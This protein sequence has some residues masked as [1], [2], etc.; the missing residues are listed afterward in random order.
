MR[1][2]SDESG[3]S[4][5]TRRDEVDGPVEHRCGVVEPLPEVLAAVD[6]VELDVR[7]DGAQR[8]RRAPRS[9]RTARARRRCRA[10]CGTAARRRAP[11]APGSP[12]AR[13]PAARPR[14][15]RSSAPRGSRSGGSPM[16]CSAIANRSAGPNQSTTPRT[17]SRRSPVSAASVAP[18]E[19]PHSTMREASTP[20]SAPC[21]LQP[22]ERGIH[23]V[24]LRGEARLAAQP[25]FARGDGETRR[26]DAIER[27]RVADARREDL[28]A[29]AQPPPAVQEH[30]EGC[31]GGFGCP[32]VER[33]RAEARP[34]ARSRSRGSRTRAI[35]RGTGTRA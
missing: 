34:A 5:V 31:A 35:S 1:V 7:A 19:T 24:Q 14:G 11:A 9:A 25:V 8:R 23:V 27:L 22:R 32:Q 28:A 10:R 12:L 26:D 3:Q 6:G 2:L 21:S 17:S 20:C 13:H 18:A 15:R 29:A 30:D 4:A 33:Q 16:S